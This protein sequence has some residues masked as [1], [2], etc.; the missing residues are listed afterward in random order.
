MEEQ[1]EIF[2]IDHN[3]KLSWTE[4]LTMNKLKWNYSTAYLICFVMEVD[5]NKDG[6]LSLDELVMGP[7]LF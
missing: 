1:M 2:D 5:K 3:D 4:I 7:F 6:E